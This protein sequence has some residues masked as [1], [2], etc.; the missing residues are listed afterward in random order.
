MV[1]GDNINTAKAI[2][3]E[4][5]I[6]TNGGVAIEGPEFRNKSPEEMR[7]L[8]P[9]IQVQFDFHQFSHIY[10]QFS[11]LYVPFNTGRLWLILYRLTSI[12]L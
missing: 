3:K 12:P 4:C 9:K 1:T 11:Q 6:L 5:A 2:A 7:D 8:I 10:H